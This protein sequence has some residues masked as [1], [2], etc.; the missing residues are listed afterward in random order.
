MNPEM[1]IEL[2]GKHRYAAYL[3]TERYDYLCD[4]EWD[5]WGLYTVAIDRSY[6]PLSL[7]T[8]DLN[9]QL[10]QIQEWQQHDWNNGELETA[11][12]KSI[13]RNGYSHIYLNLRGYS[14]SDWAYV[15]LYW[16]E[17]WLS[18]V[19]GIINELEAWFRGD[20]Y[21][22]ALEELVTYTNA[23]RPMGIIERWEIVDSTSQVILSDDKEFSLETCESY[24]GTLTEAN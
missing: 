3:S 13:S 24:L 4:Q 14:Q 11:L 12:S 19:S 23:A 10:A 21:T 1:T 9:D 17:D 5:N 20:V 7:D 15:V 16:N 6:A 8:F 2:N 18:D 22:I